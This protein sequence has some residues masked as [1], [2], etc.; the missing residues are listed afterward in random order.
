MK[1]MFTIFAMAFSSV[2]TAAITAATP[3]QFDGLSWSVSFT[4][5]SAQFFPAPCQLKASAISSFGA[6]AISTI[7]AVLTCT[8]SNQL[9]GAGDFPGVGNFYRNSS[10]GYSL[11]LL[12]NYPAG[13]QPAQMQGWLCSLSVPGLSGTCTPSIGGQITLTNAS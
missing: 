6:N 9:S 8:G 12:F 2:A 7:S 13:E 11:M 10:G 1:I 3:I 5:A 4:G